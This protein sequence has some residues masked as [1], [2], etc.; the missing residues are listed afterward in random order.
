MGAISFFLRVASIPI[1]PF[2]DVWLFVEERRLEQRKRT[3]SV[4]LN[5]WTDGT[6]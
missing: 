4:N 3:L 2:H 1:T 6:D 5:N